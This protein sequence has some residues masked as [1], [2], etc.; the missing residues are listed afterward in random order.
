MRFFHATPCA[1]TI[2]L[3]LASLP[4]LHAQAAPSPNIP[5]P[6]TLPGT[7]N[8]NPGEADDPIVHQM[9]VQ[10]AMKRNADRQQHIV[11]DTAKLLDLAQ[12]LKDEVSKNTNTSPASVARKA[13]EI[14]KL[15][16]EV[17]EKMRDSN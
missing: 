8:R 10:A 7:E 2:L 14:E 1:A 5:R 17:R 16:K 15:A 3:A 9:S 4:A 13:E 12:R 6:P 11:D